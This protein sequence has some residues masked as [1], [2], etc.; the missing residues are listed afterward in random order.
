MENNSTVFD[1]SQ[2]RREKGFFLHGVGTKD[3]LLRLDSHAAGKEFLPQKRKEILEEM[4]P[5]LK[6]KGIWAFDRGNDDEKLFSYLQKRNTKFIV[7]L[8]ESLQKLS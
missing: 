6:N 2:R 1:G 4:L 5:V 8:K 3:F 7:R